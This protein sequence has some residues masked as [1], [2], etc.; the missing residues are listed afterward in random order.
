MLSFILKS[1]VPVYSTFL[2]VAPQPSVPEQMWLMSSG[3][4]SL[5]GIMGAILLAT[6]SVAHP[7][8]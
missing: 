2:P 8:D 4:S 1:I 7:E 5:A 3:Y 6:G